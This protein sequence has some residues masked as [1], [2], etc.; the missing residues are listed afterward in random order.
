MSVPRTLTTKRKKTNIQGTVAAK[1]WLM[2]RNTNDGHT[3]ADIAGEVGY[4]AT[5][6]K[7]YLHKKFEAEANGIWSKLIRSRVEGRCEICNGPPC[8]AHHLVEKSV[9]PQHRYNLFNGVALCSGHHRFN[10]LLSPHATTTSAVAFLD[11]LSRNK[12]LQFEWYKIARATKTYGDI[13]HEHHYW[14]LL[15]IGS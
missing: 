6:V 7:Q 1:V 15:D 11:W 4:T 14:L 13:D 3:C 12:P 10:V 2:A 5:K 9:W 8:E